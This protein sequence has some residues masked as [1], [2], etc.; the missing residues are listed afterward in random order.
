MWNKPT[1]ERWHKIPKLYETE[2]VNTKDKLVHLHFFIGG[3]DWYIVE[4]GEDMDTMFG[5]AIL[6]NDLEMAEWGYMSLKEMED[7]KINGWI[8]VDC[9]AEEYWVVRPA[10]DVARIAEACRF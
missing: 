3:C 8:E 9:E 7:V 5:F 10:K 2:H 6:N 4:V 1:P